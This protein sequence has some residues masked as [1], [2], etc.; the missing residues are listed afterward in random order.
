MYLLYL[1]KFSKSLIIL[2][3]IM[4]KNSHFLY[5]RAAETMHSSYCHAEHHYKAVAL[6]LLLKLGISF[7]FEINLCVSKTLK[8]YW[9]IYFIEWN[10]LIQIKLSFLERHSHCSLCAL[11]SRLKYKTKCYDL[12]HGFDC[13]ILT[14]VIYISSFSSLSK[15][16]YSNKKSNFKLC[17]SLKSSVLK[18]MFIQDS[19]M[20]YFL[21]TM[22]NFNQFRQL[23]SI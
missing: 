15:I 12:Y 7:C 19:N 8:A 18:Y 1:L 20:Y 2:C 3:H 21:L 6:L 10:V 11:V 23:Y 13:L 22:L 14:K 5:Y 9:V 16:I 4:Q 17:N